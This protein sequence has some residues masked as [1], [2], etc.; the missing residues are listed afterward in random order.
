MADSVVIGH[1]PSPGGVRRE[2]LPEGDG[3]DCQDCQEADDL[4]LHGCDLLS[5]FRLR[6]RGTGLSDS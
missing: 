5:F 4:K 2:P 6:L 3:K 1:P